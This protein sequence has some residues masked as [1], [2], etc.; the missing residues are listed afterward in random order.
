MWCRKTQTTLGLLQQLCS[1]FCCLLFWFLCNC[2][3]WKYVIQ[4]SIY[5]SSYKIAK[6]T[7]ILCIPKRLQMTLCFIHILLF[8]LKVFLPWYI[9]RR[10]KDTAGNCCPKVFAL[11]CAQI[12][13]AHPPRG[14]WSVRAPRWHTLR[15]II[16]VALR[17]YCKHILSLCIS[18]KQDKGG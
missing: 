17:E 1:I 18:I 14:G 11:F 8:M 12:Y 4:R 10:Y 3:Y 5:K 6:R 13:P 7:V 2:F 15:G 16:Y 9:C